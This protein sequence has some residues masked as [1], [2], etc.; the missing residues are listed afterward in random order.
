[1]YF[2]Q[3]PDETLQE[4]GRR[5]VTIVLREMQVEHAHVFGD[6]DGRKWVRRY[7]DF[8]GVCLSPTHPIDAARRNP[9][10]FVGKNGDAANMFEHGGVKGADIAGCQF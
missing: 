10:S 7:E 6:F 8:K 3:S 5:Y 9:V 4:R 1:V 2:P